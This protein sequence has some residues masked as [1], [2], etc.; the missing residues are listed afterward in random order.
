MHVCVY[1]VVHRYFY[2]KLSL[3]TPPREFATIIDTGSTMTYIPCAN[4]Q[5]CGKHMVCTQQSA[6]IKVASACICW[7]RHE[8]SLQLSRPVVLEVW[9]ALQ[10]AASYH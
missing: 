10:W 2:A 6:A 9:C 1:I 3:G 7:W 5:H 4:C 8:S